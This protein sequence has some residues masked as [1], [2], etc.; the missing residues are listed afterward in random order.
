MHHLFFGQTINYRLDQVLSETTAQRACSNTVLLPL[1]AEYLTLLGN[2]FAGNM[3]SLLFHLFQSVIQ[4][5]DDDALSRKENQGIVS[6][7]STMTREAK[8]SLARL[9]L[10]ALQDGENDDSFGGLEWVSRSYQIERMEFVRV[11][12]SRLVEQYS[13]HTSQKI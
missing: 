11:V 9:A 6:S 4:P 7:T 12:A 5:V 1:E 10:E 13:T 8:L 3:E 2:R